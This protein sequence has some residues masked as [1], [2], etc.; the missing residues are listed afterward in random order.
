MPDAGLLSGLE[1]AAFRG[2][3]VRLLIPKEADVP[4]VHLA[5]YAVIGPLLA[6]GVQVRHYTP[7]FMHTKAF[8]VDDRAAGVGTLN[9]DNR[10]IRLN[11]EITALLMDREAVARVRAMFERD[12]E[13]TEPLTAAEVADRSFWG[14][15][16]SR[17]AYLLAPIL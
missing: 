4:L 6:A 11:F 1:L 5:K 7:G 8:L 16:G 10:S 13:R 12:F 2:V 15:V 17:A 3:D 9:L 14:K